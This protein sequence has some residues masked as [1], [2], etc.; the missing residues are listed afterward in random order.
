MKLINSFLAIVL[1]ASMMIGCGTKSNNVDE[2]VIPVEV[3]T[4]EKL[5][6][7]RTLDF[8]GTIM[9]WRETNL[10]AQTSGRIEKIFVKEGD[11]VKEGDI[12]VQMDDTQLTQARI[13][14]ELA[15]EDFQR[16]KPLFDEGSISPQQFEKV[17]GG[18]ETAKATYELILRNTQLRAPF[19]GIIT[20]KRMNEGE[21]FLLAPGSGGAP[22][23][24]NLMQISQLKVLVNAPESDFPNVRLGQKATLVV[25]IYPN[26]TFSGTVSRVDPVINPT[27]RSFT[28]ELKIP[29]DKRILRPGMFARVMIKTGDIDALIIPRSA[30]IKQLGTNILYT[31]IIENDA[32]KRREVTLGKEMDA[33]VEVLSGLEIGNQLVVKGMG[34]LKDGSRVQIVSSN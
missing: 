7:E 20:A 29:N 18:Y 3:K 6:V 27:T 16:M 14:Y 17:K 33:I 24:V 21:V 10:G 28:V 2:P 32:A 1:L 30:L 26:Q 25:D 23:V 19:S 15:K 12:L 5:K 13:Q 8:A 22:S 4:V 9:A 34:R 11:E 31:Y